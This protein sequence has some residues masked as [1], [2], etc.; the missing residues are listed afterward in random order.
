MRA[1]GKNEAQQLESFIVKQLLKTSGLFK[2]SDAAGGSLT[3]DMFA[4]TLSEAIAGGGGFGIAK[5]ISPLPLGEREASEAPITS[6]FGDRIDPI[7]GQHSNHTG[8]DLGAAEGTPIPAAK[9]GVVIFAGERGGYGNA[10]E[11]AHPDGTSTLYAHASGVAVNP[12]DH[13]DAGDVLGW[14]GQTG[15]TTGPHLHLEV[16]KAGQFIDPTVALKAYRLRAEE[17]G[18]DSP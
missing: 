1:S 16:R 7:N 9:D 8:V 10:I 15:R 13:V 12:G 6:Q 18:G 2:G 4:D 14:V 17:N 11:V 3:A 5:M